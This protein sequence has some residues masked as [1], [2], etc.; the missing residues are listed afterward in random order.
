MRQNGVGNLTF[1]RGTT[2]LATSSN[3]FSI[4]AWYYLECKAKI[5]STTGTYEVRINGT[6]TGWIPAVTGANTRNGGNNQV[7]GTRLGWTTGNQGIQYDD[8][9]VCDTT[10]SVNIDFLGPQVV[11]T[12]R[13]MGAGNYS[14]WTPN[15]GLNFSNVN[16]LQTDNDGTFNQSST[17]GQKDSFVM[18]DLSAGGTVSAIQHVLYAKQSVGAQRSIRPV[19]RSGGTDF[20]GATVNTGTSYTMAL[21][22]DDVNPATGAAFTP[23]EINAAEFGYELVS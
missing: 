1:N 3:T 20:A 15:L 17:A 16:D 12:V 14:Q 13:P 11:E 19:Q 21:D 18:S 10:G 5:N 7:T 23:F 22:L 9:Y 6:S 8:L 2:A 4:G